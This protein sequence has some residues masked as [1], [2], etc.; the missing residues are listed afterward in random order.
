MISIMKKIYFTLFAIALFF[1]SVKAQE[2]TRYYLNNNI[3]T[4][5]KDSATYQIKFKTAENGLVNFE[6]YCMDGRLKEKGTFQ[7]MTTL[8]REGEITAFYPNGNKK[9]VAFYAD[10]LPNGIK[11]HYFPSGKVNYKILVNSAGY[12]ETHQKEESIK[13]LFSVNRDGETTLEDGNGKFIAY[14]EALEVS[15]EGSVKNTM[16]DGVWKG[17]DKGNLIFSE[18]YQNGKLM[19][20]ESYA[21]DGKVYNYQHR[22]KRPEPRGGI[23]N[24]YTYVI[25]AMQDLDL[26]NEKMVM[27]FVIDVNGNLKNI[28]VINSS[29]H[30]INSLAVSTL[31]N[32]PKWDPALE[33][34]KPVQVAYFMPISIRY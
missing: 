19:K 32:A 26:N 16:A 1:V 17:F 3:A 27:K 31:K 33:Q 23:N 14:N 15:Q 2:V 28:E 29:N 30:K 5:S 22:N 9:D 7:N 8:V 34:G 13:Y 20:G 6:R 12:G 4:Q 21:A 10:G 11:T 18:F 24:F 25:N